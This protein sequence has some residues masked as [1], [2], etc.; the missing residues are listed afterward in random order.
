MKP[1][2]IKSVVQQFKDIIDQTDPK[3]DPM[4]NSKT[5]FLPVDVEENE[6]EKS[7]EDK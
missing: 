6:Q 5:G 4:A 1:K 2:K 7:K 3:L